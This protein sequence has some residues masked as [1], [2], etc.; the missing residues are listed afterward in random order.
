MTV[1]ARGV[2]LVGASGG[3]GATDVEAGAFDLL[4][5]HLDGRLED[6]EIATH[7]SQ[8]GISQVYERRVDLVPPHAIMLHPRGARTR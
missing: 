8:R 5:E 2:R 3:T 7:L 6:V 4:K 1:S